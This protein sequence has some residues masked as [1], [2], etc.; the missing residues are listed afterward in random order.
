MR[1]RRIGMVAEIN[2][3]PMKSMRAEPMETADL[4]WTGLPGDRQYAYFKQA[5]RSRFPWL[6]GRDVADLVLWTARYEEAADSRPPTP[7]VTSPDGQAHAADDPAVLARLAEAADEPVA[8]LQIGRGCFDAMPISVLAT[9]T[10]AALDAANGAPLGTRRFRAN[11]VIRTDPDA[12][13][14]IEWCGRSLRF[15]EGA[16][17]PR[18]AVDCPIPRCAMVTID[19]DTASR[20]PAVLRRVAQEF[21]NEIGAYATAERLGRIA[22]GD[23]VWLVERG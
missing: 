8:L 22:C 9:T 19:P 13:R 3:F 18:I 21:D 16:E 1:E 6:T 7:R 2:R 10:E 12:G 23:P 15:G 20:D 5:N 11:L 4:N 17:A 14:E